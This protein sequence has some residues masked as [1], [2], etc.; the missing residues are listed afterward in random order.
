MSSPSP[1][2]PGRPQEPLTLCRLPEGADAPKAAHSWEA[3]GLAPVWEWGWFALTISTSPAPPPARHC[4]TP[5]L[6]PLRLA[7]PSLGVAE[8]PTVTSA[9][10]PSWRQE[11]SRPWDSFQPI[12]ASASDAPFHS[13]H[14][15][16]GRP[17]SLDS[18]FQA[19]LVKARASHALGCDEKRRCAC[20]LTS[21]HEPTHLLPRGRLIDQLSDV[22]N[23]IA[24]SSKHLMI[25]K[26]IGKIMNAK[27]LA[28]VFPLLPF[29]LKL[30]RFDETGFLN[31]IF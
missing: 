7:H 11:L 15:P 12:Q 22:E 4:P 29:H 6:A 23:G 3:D 18:K 5:V 31:L 25:L 14:I 2:I 24:Q 17:S 13:T 19:G 20:V 27:T 8:I 1:L 21:A 16:G 28:R 10:R 9:Q 26:I 30:S